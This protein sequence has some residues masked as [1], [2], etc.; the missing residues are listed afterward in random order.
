MY[1]QVAQWSQPDAQW[2][3]WQGNCHAVQGADLQ[4]KGADQKII[5]EQSTW[6]LQNHI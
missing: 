4:T 2:A 3:Y 1:P 5:F 6:D